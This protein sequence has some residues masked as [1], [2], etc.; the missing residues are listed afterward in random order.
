M[1][2]DRLKELAHTKRLEAIN[3]IYEKALTKLLG[4]L[5]PYDK[6]GKMNPRVT[7]INE[8]FDAAMARLGAKDE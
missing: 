5:L 7:V 6:D 2:N 1:I 4:M 3:A 8:A